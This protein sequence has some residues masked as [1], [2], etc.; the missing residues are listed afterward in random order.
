LGAEADAATRV[1]FVEALGRIRHRP[2]V[3]LLSKILEDRVQAEDLRIAAAGALARIGDARAVPVLARTYSKGDKGLTKMF[4]SI[5]APVRAAAARALAA[6]PMVKEAR[7]AMRAAREDADPSV[8]AVAQQALY[9]PLQE[10]FGERSMAVQPASTAAEIRPEDKSGGSLVEV[11]L[12]SLLE[13]LAGLEVR[14]TL[15]LAYGG[16]TARV[17]MD[18][19]LVVAVEYEGR[20]DHD[21]LPFLGARREG[22]W[23]FQPGDMPTSRRMLMTVEGVVEAMKRARP[24]SSSSFPAQ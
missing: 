14:G 24:G 9:A 15:H 8:R 11:P 20:R 19:G 23:L 12:E 16:P 1:A 10:C 21:A 18:S 2:A 22:F 5:P 13:R 6:F 4:R 7:D 3:D 17:G